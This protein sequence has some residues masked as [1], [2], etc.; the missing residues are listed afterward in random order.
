MKNILS[1]LEKSNSYGV[2]FPLLRDGEKGA[3]VTLTMTIISFV[4]CCYDNSEESR[5]LFLITSGL[6]LG[7]KHQKKKDTSN[8]QQS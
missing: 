7:R 2:A 4:L 8:V 5:Y 6:Y 3:S 1:W